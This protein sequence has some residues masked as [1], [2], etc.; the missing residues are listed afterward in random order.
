MPIG[1]P[2]AGQIFEGAKYRPGALRRKNAFLIHQLVYR[3]GKVQGNAGG[4]FKA[5]TEPLQTPADDFGKSF[6]RK[7][8]VHHV[9]IAQS[10]Y[11]LGPEALEQGGFHGTEVHA[12]VEAPHLVG[13]EFG[14]GMVGAL[15]GGVE[16]AGHNHQ[17]LLAVEQPRGLELSHCFLHK[18]EGACAVELVQCL[19][20]VQTGGEL[21]LAAFPQGIHAFGFDKREG[22]TVGLKAIFSTGHIE[23]FPVAGFLRHHQSLLHLHPQRQSQLELLL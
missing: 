10:G 18:S 7:G 23:N 17:V 3:G 20:Q 22:A 21:L 8:W 13:L 12:L 16:V 11:L 4:G 9:V 6:V 5:R 1:E 2:A 15:V 19:A 14:V